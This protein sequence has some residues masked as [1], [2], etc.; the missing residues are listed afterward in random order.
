MTT[1]DTGLNDGEDNDEETAEQ[2]INPSIV[3]ICDR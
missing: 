1:K 2:I 3:N